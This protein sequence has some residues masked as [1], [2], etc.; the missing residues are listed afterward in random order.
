V[1]ATNDDAAADQSVS[2]AVRRLHAAM[3]NVAMGDV[4]AIKALYSHGPDVTSFFG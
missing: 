3:A 2:S 1:N 4:A